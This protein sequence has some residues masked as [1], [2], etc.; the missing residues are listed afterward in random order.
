MDGYYFILK[1]HNSL[2]PNQLL[3]NNFRFVKWMRNGA[4][5]FEINT[6]QRKVIPTEILII[7]Y[8]IHIRNNRINTPIIIN[9]NWLIANGH[10]EWCFIEVIVYLLNNF[11]HNL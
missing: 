2:I 11:D 5:Q 9:Q 10:S 3:G 7:A 4:L 6:N 1:L 8:H